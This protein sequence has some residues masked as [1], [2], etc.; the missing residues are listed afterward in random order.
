MMIASTNKQSSIIYT[1][2]PAITILHKVYT[3]MYM[4]QEEYI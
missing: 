3:Y 4:N 1:K 2:R